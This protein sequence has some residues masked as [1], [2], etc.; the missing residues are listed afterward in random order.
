MFHLMQFLTGYIGADLSGYPK[1]QA[2][3]AKVEGNPKVATWL[4]KRPVTS[5]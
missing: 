2:L 5:F 3:K 1:L 4:A